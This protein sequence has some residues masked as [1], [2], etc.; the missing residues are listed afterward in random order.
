MT[1]LGR[2]VAWVALA[3]LGSACASGIA[4]HPTLDPGAVKP[5]QAVAAPEAVRAA[6]VRS[7][8]RAVIIGGGP[9]KAHNQVAIESN[10]RYVGRLLPAASQYHV[11]FTDGDLRSENVQFREARVLA[12]RAPDLPRLDGG[13]DLPAVR[14]ELTAAA[15]G[16]RTHPESDVLLYFTGHG[17]PD[18]RTTYANN[19]FDL[20]AGGR[21]TV[22]NLAGSLKAFP[23]AT[24]ITLVMVQ[25]FSG[26]F[27]N[28]L[29]EDGD[30]QGALIE[31]HVAGF[32]AAVPQRVAAGCTPAINEAD[33]KD[34]TG[35]FF[36]ALTGQDRMGRPVSG[37]DYDHDGR[38]GMNEAFAWA[39]VHDDSIDTPVCTSDTFLRRFVTTPD[40][41]IFK[42]SF[43]TLESWAAPAQRAALDGLADALRLAGDDRLRVAFE[44]FGRMRPDSMLIDDVRL[45]RLVSLTRSIALAHTL[46]LSGDET[47]RR[48]FAELLFAESRNP[49][50]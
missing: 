17:S 10:V 20:W 33:Y 49:L 50:H 39:L 9:D 31:Q 5:P 14:A 38:V 22:T 8:L 1:R 21:L 30:P 40:S 19:W 26:A 29:F 16:A 47:T 46:G 11:L 28:V 48:R 13:A 23:P 7:P 27:G 25:C 34:F 42:A 32:F 36:A 35:Y 4:A 3:I 45:I 18:R 12:Y 41:E 15:A 37:A 43:K 6:E 2:F 24:P 44:K